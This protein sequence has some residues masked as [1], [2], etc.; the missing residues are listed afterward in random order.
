MPGE[1]QSENFEDLSKELAELPGEIKEEAPEK[2][3][4]EV[5]EMEEPSKEELEDIHEQREQVEKTTEAS[6]ELLVAMVSEAESPEEIKKIMG[7]VDRMSLL[8]RAETLEVL[9]EKPLEAIEPL[10]DEHK[11]VNPSYI[12]RLIEK[13]VSGK[14]GTEEVVVVET[15]YKPKEGAAGGVKWLQSFW[16]NPDGRAWLR[17]FYGVDL[18]GGRKLEDFFPVLRKKVCGRELK[19]IHCTYGSGL[20]A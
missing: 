8:V 19:R 2:A 9:P 13:R 14:E 18:E 1:K 7:K 20:P 5:L 6:A 12:L 11:G 15:V 4:P 3:G 16:E 17:D 10:G